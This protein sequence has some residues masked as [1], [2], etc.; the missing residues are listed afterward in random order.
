MNIYVKHCS[1]L[2]SGGCIIIAAGT[3]KV[4]EKIAKKELKPFTYDYFDKVEIVPGASYKGARG[5]VLVSDYYI[6]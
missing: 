1:E 5:K 4:A 3:A 2:Y 6:E